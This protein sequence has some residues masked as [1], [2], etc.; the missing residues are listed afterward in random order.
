GTSL[1]DFPNSFSDNE[2]LVFL[3]IT[4]DTSADIYALSLGDK[5]EAHPLLHTLAFEGG[6]K[7]SPDGH[8]MAY[9]SNESGQMQVYVRPFP[10]LDR[11]TQVSTEGGTAPIWNPSGRELFYL[12]DNKM[13]VVDVT[14]SS[15]LALSAPRLLFEQRHSFGGNATN[16]NY[17]VS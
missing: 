12:N 1:S 9:V 5:P 14:T 13:M 16:A 15:E 17:D 3:R 6:A 11:K 2:T 4:A 7:I 8:W 10:G